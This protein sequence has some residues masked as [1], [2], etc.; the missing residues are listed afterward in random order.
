MASAGARTEWSDGATD[1]AT[2]LVAALVGSGRTLATGESLTAGLVT[3]ALARVPGAS[4]VLRGG[5]TA[6]WVEAKTSLLGVPLETIERCGVVSSEVAVAMARGA[7]RAFGAEV[8]VGTTGV[9]G[10]GAADGH[11]AGTAFVA[12]TC[13]GVARVRQVH[14]AGP[15]ACLRRGVVGVAVALALEV[16]EDLCGVWEREHP[17]GLER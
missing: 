8:G 14:L 9:A 6:Y 12:V 17:G 13:D 1:A 4:V 5:V 11:P 10:P 2:R 16:V 3:D 15:R 7:A